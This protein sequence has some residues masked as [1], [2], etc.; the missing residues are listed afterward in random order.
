M[1]SWQL[2][3]G[4]GIAH[5]FHG[6]SRLVTPEPVYDQHTYTKIAPW[7]KRRRNRRRNKVARA[8][9]KANRAV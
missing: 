6:T 1:K 5:G 2:R 4:M 9:R 3:R 8:S 7:V